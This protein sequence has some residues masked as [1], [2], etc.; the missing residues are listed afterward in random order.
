M[1]EDAPV[2]GGV[3]DAAAGC[4]SSSPDAA[5]VGG[6]GGAGVVIGVGDALA[7]GAHGERGGRGHVHV[8]VRRD[9]LERSQLLHLLLQPPVLL[10]ERLA[11]ALQEL[12]V[13][14][15]LLQLRP[16]LVTQAAKNN[17]FRI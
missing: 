11:A 14:L 5:A 9:E 13:H 12:A 3:D 1:A 8:E 15:R 2:G 4:G 7:G 16:E 6:G 10:R 17:G